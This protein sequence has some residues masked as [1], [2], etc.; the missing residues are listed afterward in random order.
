[1]G[2]PLDPL[3]ANVFMSHFERKH[4]ERM[5]ELGLKTWMR[6]VDDIHATVGDKRQAIVICM[7]LNEQHPNIKFTIEQE[8]KNR[9][10]FLV[11]CSRS[12]TKSKMWKKYQWLCTACN[13]TRAETNTLVRLSEYCATDS[14]N[15]ARMCHQ[16]VISMSKPWLDSTRSKYSIRQP[17]T[18]NWKWR[19]CYQN[20]TSSLAHSPATR[21]TH[22][23]S[24]HTRNSNSKSNGG[25]YMYFNISPLCMSGRFPL[26]NLFTV[27]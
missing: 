25:S 7:F 18:P 13:A 17:R 9:L 10:P 6:F 3:F 16:R 5:K 20:W 11:T 22:Y 21:S 15:I 1:M 26:K 8:I 12:K 24:R 23:W 4:M 14:K 19:S 27:I 2:S